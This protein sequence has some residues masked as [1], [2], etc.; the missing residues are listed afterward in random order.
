[1]RRQA[2][3]AHVERLEASPFA[4][5]Q[6][7]D[8][9]DYVIEEDAMKPITKITI[10]TAIVPIAFAIRE[11]ARFQRV[12]AEHAVA[13]EKF[14][15]AL[16][17]SKARQAEAGA[18]GVGRDTEACIEWAMAD[19]HPGAGNCS[20]CMDAL[21]GCL[22]TATRSAS[23]CAAIP[24]YAVRLSP[25]EEAASDA[26][27]KAQSAKYGLTDWTCSAMFKFVQLHCQR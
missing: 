27:Q 22:A 11:T 17:Q 20:T 15:A 1:M 5:G 12:D 3:S 4:D 21:R 2:P 7:L 18:A 19:C 14:N 23:T 25:D 16:E 24:R 9:A 6:V 13:E 10:G 8:K 26:W